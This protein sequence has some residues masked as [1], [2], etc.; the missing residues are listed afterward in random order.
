MET[1]KG[2]IT[3]VVISPNTPEE[4]EFLEMFLDQLLESLSDLFWGSI[5]NEATLMEI[6][7][8]TINCYN[9]WLFKRKPNTMKFE[10]LVYK[11]PERIYVDLRGKQ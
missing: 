8:M 2:G 3:H 5:M 10:A 7:V 11:F 1:T 6:N 9:E 4:K